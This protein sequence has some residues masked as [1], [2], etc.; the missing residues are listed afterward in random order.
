M[1]SFGGR[2]RR[3]F[4][5]PETSSVFHCHWMFFAGPAIRRAIL[6]LDRNCTADRAKE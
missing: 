4:G 2:A 6:D 3:A 1:K 5:N